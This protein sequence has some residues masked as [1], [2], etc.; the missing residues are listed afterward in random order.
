MEKGFRDNK[1]HKREQFIRVMHKIYSRLLTSMHLPSIV[2]ARQETS[3]DDRLFFLL[4]VKKIAENHQDTE[5]WRIRRCSSLS[6]APYLSYI[7]DEIHSWFV[8][9]EIC[10][11][12]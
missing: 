7:M 5:K 11:F 8:G 6:V 4:A 2:K 9:P 1:D 12:L 3:T 10:Q